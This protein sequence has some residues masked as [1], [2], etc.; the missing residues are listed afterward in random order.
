M[1]KPMTRTNAV[2]TTQITRA[3]AV[4]LAAGAV[5]LGLTGLPDRLLPPEGSTLPG[6]VGGVV[7]VGVPPGM[8]P[9]GTGTNAVVRPTSFSPVDAGA[10]S[11]RFAM[12]DNAPKIPVA[13]GVIV[14]T[15]NGPEVI[16]AQ[17]SPPASGIA[18]R[19]RFLGV[20]RLGEQNAAFVNVDGRQRFVQEGARLAPPTDR[21]EFSELI[22]ERILGTTIVVGDGTHQE[23]LNLA[24]RTGPAVTMADGGVVNQVDIPTE[25]PASNRREMPQEE[26]DRR[27]RMLDRQRSGNLGEGASRRVMPETVGRTTNMRG[28][29]S[30]AAQSADE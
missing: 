28:N 30:P 20:V 23:R 10:L 21:P 25:T 12:L 8:P 9:A 1:T 16:I 19:V 14:T 22:V 26:L 15:D 3:A 13:N 7:G 18:D 17:E 4:V 6:A 11:T 27:N 29:R 2:L 5:A 24:Q